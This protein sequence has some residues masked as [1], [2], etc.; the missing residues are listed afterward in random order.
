M[1]RLASFTVFDFEIRH[2]SAGFGD[3]DRV[4]VERQNVPFAGRELGNLRQELPQRCKIE[5]WPAAR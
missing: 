1:R 3:E 5:L 2:P 4:E